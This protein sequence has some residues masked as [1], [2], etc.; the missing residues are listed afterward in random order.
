M[1]DS[2]KGSDEAIETVPNVVEILDDSP[3][4]DLKLMQLILTLIFS[5]LKHKNTEKIKSK[6][7]RSNSPCEDSCS[8]ETLCLTR[9][10]FYFSR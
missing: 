4:D 7:S 1:K 9:V 10:S 8:L 3:Y 2:Y 6:I 5:L